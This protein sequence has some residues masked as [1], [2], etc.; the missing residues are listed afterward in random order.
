MRA[1][2]GSQRSQAKVSPVY[3]APLCWFERSLASSAEDRKA[4]RGR[5]DE[6]LGGERGNAFI[7]NKA[8]ANKSRA[9]NH[10]VLLANLLA[11][12]QKFEFKSYFNGV[13][14]D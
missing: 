2:E 5:D 9:L 13:H 6:D 7:K 14:N 8:N 3:S 1:L 4:E 10:F 12:P 11:L